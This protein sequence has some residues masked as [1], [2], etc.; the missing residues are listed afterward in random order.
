MYL[1]GRGRGLKRKCVVIWV[2][3]KVFLFRYVFFFR[4]FFFWEMP[5]DL[6]NKVNLYTRLFTESFF[7]MRCTFVFLSFNNVDN[8]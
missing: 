5:F 2:K 1:G 6:F 7:N 8:W 3:F 4:L